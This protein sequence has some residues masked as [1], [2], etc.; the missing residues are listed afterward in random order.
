[1]PEASATQPIP[2]ASDSGLAKRFLELFAQPLIAFATALIIYLL[3]ARFNAY[4]W[5]R[6][7]YAFF[8]Y[9]AD[10]FLHGQLALRDNLEQVRDLVIYEGRLYL[11]WPPFPAIV[12]M[13][14]VAI[15][16][17]G[18][19]DVLYTA[20]IGAA[21]AGL[22]AWLLALA[23]RHGVAPLSASR[24]AILVLTMAFGS[25][26]LILAPFGTVW[27]TAQLLGLA[28][29]LLAAIA[30]IGIRGSWGY[31]LTGFALACAGGTR[32]ALVFNG[33][34]L[35]YY[36]LRRDWARP[37]VWRLRAVAMGLV[38]LLV[39]AVLTGWYNVARFGKPL[40]TG[41]QWHNMALEFVED[42]ERYGFFN[43]H[44]LPINFH[45]QFWGY[46]VFSDDRWKG[47]GLFWMTPVL[48]GAFAG[49]WIWRRNGLTWALVASC[50]LIYIPIGLLFG[51]GYITF[52]PRYLLDMMVPLV[53]L[54]ALG[55]R[56]WPLW[57]LLL[58]L[59]ISCATYIYGSWQWWEIFRLL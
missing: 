21:T 8:N 28:C 53:L 19:S 17:V 26:Q 27:F 22:F 9:L 18:L 4:G 43:V 42:Y 39:L 58:L 6:T 51:T 56:R 20:V 24:R 48:L 25:V 36:L 38:P 37:L 32:N 30:A 2:E 16:G 10:A 31:F 40:E 45:Y 49:W 55:I 35:A 34:W 13:P 23:D 52:G 12:L 46:T 41:L 33:L 54:T 11:Y 59:L 47:G 29:V 1:M 5:N 57:L 3:R 15:F 50:L 44:F 14:L 7:E